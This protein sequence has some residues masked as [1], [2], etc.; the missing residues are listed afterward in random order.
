MKEFK[1]SMGSRD[2]IFIRK[3][4]YVK[5][6]TGETTTSTTSGI[7]AIKVNGKTQSIESGVVNITTPV[8][9]QYKNASFFPNV[10]SEDGVY[11][12]IENNKTYRFNV[13]D[14]TYY[15]VGSDYEE[16]TTINGNC[17]G[18]I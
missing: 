2:D 1:I 18:G 9:E 15:C 12:D 8:V 11:I 17:S 4:C 16:I 13:E 10:G 14:K 3:N 6:T 5:P 7:K